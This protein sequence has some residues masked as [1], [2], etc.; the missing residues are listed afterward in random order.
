MLRLPKTR[1]GN[2]R[3]GKR[4]SGWTE[5]TLW[6][7]VLVEYALIILNEW[8]AVPKS[9]SSEETSSARTSSTSLNLGSTA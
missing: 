9:G 1:R 8:K 3:S 6:S 4:T 2:P 5:W 7:A